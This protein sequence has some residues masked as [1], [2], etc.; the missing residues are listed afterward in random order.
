MKQNDED[1][2]VF[3]GKLEGPGKPQVLASHRPNV[4]LSQP[5]THVD[6]E[7][8]SDVSMDADQ[9]SIQLSDGPNSRRSSKVEV[10]QVEQANNVDD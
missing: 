1:E 10:A 4:E 2:M 9:I 8:G 6:S 3:D 7:P 5:G